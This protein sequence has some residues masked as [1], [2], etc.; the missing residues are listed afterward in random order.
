MRK[1]KASPGVIPTVA[2]PPPLETVVE[3]DPAEPV[4]RAMLAVADD[5]GRLLDDARKEA[6]T[7]IIR[8]ASAELPKALDRFVAQRY[9]ALYLAAAALG[10]GLVG[11][12]TALGYYCRGGG[13]VT[14]MACADQ[15]GG[16][17][18]WVWVRPPV[19]H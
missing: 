6:G 3:G 5:V 15:D 13:D 12:G 7:Q 11:F 4:I 8:V 18:C 10:I 1:P 14:G 19:H 2:A 16:R 17:F 9:R